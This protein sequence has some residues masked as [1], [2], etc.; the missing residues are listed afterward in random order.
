MRSARRYLNGADRSSGSGLGWHPHNLVGV[1]LRAWVLS[2]TYRAAFPVMR[3]VWFVTRPAVD[4]AKCVVWD[5]D[6][7]LL[8]RHTYGNRKEWLLPGGTV[9]RGEPPIDTA[10]REIREET[11]L[12][13]ERWRPLGAVH[14]KVD[15]RR[16]AIHCFAARLAPGA[17]RELRLDRSEILD[18]GWFRLAALPSPIG[19]LTHQILELDGAGVRS[20]AVTGQT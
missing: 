16:N 18:A 7:L 9:R 5:D 6:H 19:E 4:G 1:S 14:A 11:G 3:V 17:G 12:V 15:N 8:V 2:R 20:G 13:I 10:R